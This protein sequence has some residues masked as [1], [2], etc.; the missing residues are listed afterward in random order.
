MEY[1]VPGAGVRVH[2]SLTTIKSIRLYLGVLDL[3]TRLHEED[4]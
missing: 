4:A 2:L 3:A 1:H